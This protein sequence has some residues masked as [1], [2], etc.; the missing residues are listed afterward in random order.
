MHR[1]AV[2][3]IALLGLCSL[4]SADQLE[5]TEGTHAYLGDASVA[6][7]DSSIH[8]LS[9]VGSDDDQDGF[10]DTLNVL[11]FDTLE[12]KDFVYDE[13]N[14]QYVAADGDTLQFNDGSITHA[15]HGNAGYGSIN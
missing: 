12:F 2:S 6:Y 1:W 10:V 13:A 9:I 15:N 4:S 8:F 11:D 3:A 14:D 7:G 5:N